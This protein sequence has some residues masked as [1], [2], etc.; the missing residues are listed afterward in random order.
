MKDGER[1]GTVDR[2]CGDEVSVTQLHQRRCPFFLTPK[3]E[4]RMLRFA[5][6][7]RMAYCL[8][9]QFKQC[10]QTRVS[11]SSS[12]CESLPLNSVP[13]LVSPFSRHCHP[14]YVG[15][16]S[17]SVFVNFPEGNQNQLI[18]SHMRERGHLTA[19][20]P[21]LGLSRLQISQLQR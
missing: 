7:K 1:G 9:W 14:N 12:R 15:N 10:S 20:S 3:W 6:I 5:K 8:A 17:F 13:L 18:L 4:L 21:T 11:L 19:P 16:V 2:K